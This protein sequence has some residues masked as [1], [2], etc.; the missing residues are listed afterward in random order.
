[1]S[2]RIVF[3][4]G[5]HEGYHSQQYL[6]NDT[7]LYAFEACPDMI[8][9]LE[10]K[11]SNV[12]NFI[13]IKKAVSNFSGKAIFNLAKQEDYGCSSLLEFS[14]KANEQWVGRSFKITDKIEVDVIKL[15]DFIEENSI[16]KIDYFHC[17][18]Q[19]SDL[20][21]LK[22]M[23]KYLNI[24]EAGQIEAADKEDILYYGQNKTQECVKFLELN[25]FNIDRIQGNDFQNPDGTTNEVN[26]YFSKKRI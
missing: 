22:G 13:L 17:D 23:G 24:I 5:A 1:M 21:V 12:S 2:N 11:F 16:N 19:G 10:N 8:S 4:V 18:T 20:N 6:N 26:I 7:V 3:D 14:E 15:E 25:G 9:V